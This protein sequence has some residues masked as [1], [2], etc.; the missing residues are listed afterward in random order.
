MKPKLLNIRE[1][2][3]HVQL[4]LDNLEKYGYCPAIQE[5]CQIASLVNRSILRKHEETR[6]AGNRKDLRIG[7]A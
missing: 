2:L 4:I 6:T 5:T 3:K 7:A 1:H